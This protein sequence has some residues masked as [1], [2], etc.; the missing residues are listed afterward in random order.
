MHIYLYTLIFLHS[1]SYLLH[2]CISRT[3]EILHPMRKYLLNTAKTYCITASLEPPL[4][5]VGSKT[6]ISDELAE[7][8]N[9]YVTH[10][11]ADC[12]AQPASFILK[13]CITA[14]VHIRG[15]SFNR[16]GGSD[17]IFKK[18]ILFPNF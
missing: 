8:K 2:N 1:I 13:A 10:P 4:A 7:P 17:L 14:Q 9:L 5:S 6:F 11:S 16:M 15:W 12:F 18:N 3:V